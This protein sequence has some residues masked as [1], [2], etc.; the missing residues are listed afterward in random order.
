MFKLLRLSVG[1]LATLVSFCGTVLADDV[2]HVDLMGTWEGTHNI[3][4]A[5]THP[6][7]P[8]EIIEFDTQVEIYKQ[9]ENLFWLANRWRVTGD[10]AW[11][12]EFAVGTFLANDK[13]HFV[14][15]EMGGHENPVALPGFFLG[16]IDDDVMYLTYDG[17]G[18]GVAF[19]A[20]LTRVTE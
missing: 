5:R 19:N 11:E 12:E 13:D 3:G 4:F 14:F 6:T 17:A 8:D 2:Q 7:F 1:A 20:I 15:S 10:T 18:E 16:R 9:V